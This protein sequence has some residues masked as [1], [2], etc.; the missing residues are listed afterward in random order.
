MKPRKIVTINISVPNDGKDYNVI[1]CVADATPAGASD[2]DRRRELTH[3]VW[4]V[5]AGETEPK[6]VR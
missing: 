2:Y 6:L 1:T 5:A 3:H 4:S